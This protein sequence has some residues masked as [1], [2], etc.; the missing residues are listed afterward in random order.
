MT[1]EAAQYSVSG[2]KAL[3]IGGTGGVGGEIS[4]I[5]AGGGAR[6]VVH[7]PDPSKLESLSKGLS[8]GGRAIETLAYR[9]P[10]LGLG[11]FM[12]K[13][14]AFLP[15]DILV[16]GFGPFLRAALASTPPSA[17]EE[18]ALLNLALPGALVSACLP[19]MAASSYG[20]ILLFGGSRTEQPR[21]ALTNTAYAA[22]KTGLGVIAR[23]IAK[24]Y[25]AS[26]VSCTVICP[27]SADSAPV[28]AAAA[29]IRRDTAGSRLGQD[30]RS[31]ADWALRLVLDRDATFNGA[32]ITADRGF[33]A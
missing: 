31:L 22:A 4:A 9:F 1:H 27:G 21:A 30:P 13:V 32:V 23:T 6:L 29:E 14:S 3:V 33:L 2:K 19:G 20:R 26:G 16:V 12:E 5:L 8:V 10:G 18:M 24:E 7:G 15:V 11:P 25:A 28:S 17:W